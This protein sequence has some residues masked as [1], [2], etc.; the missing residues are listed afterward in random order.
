MKK[1][2]YRETVEYAMLAELAKK[3]NLKPEQYLKN[4][5]QETYGKQKR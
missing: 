5:I 3:T 2:V 1:P 4:L